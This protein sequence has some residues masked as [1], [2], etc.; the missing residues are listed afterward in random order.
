M[1]ATQ[2]RENP[3][4]ERDRRPAHERAAGDERRRCEECSEPGSPLEEVR[5]LVAE[6]AGTFALTLAAAGGEVIAQVSGGE[7]SHAARVVAPGLVVLALI[8]AIGNVSGA[9]FNPAVTF[10][11]ALRGVFRWRRVPAYWLAELCGALLAAVLLRWLFGTVAHL[12]ATMPHHGVR[13]AFVMEIALTWLLVMVILGTA[14]RHHLLGPNAAIAV[15]ATIALCGLFAGPVSGASMNPARSL[16]PA[17][18]AGETADVWI[19]LVAPFLGAALAVGLTWLL[20]GGP[21]DGEGEAAG[22]EHQH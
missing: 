14:T 5:C 11:F 22:G 2:E 16:G 12:G 1:V 9:H 15:G 18:V 6:M 20:R 19:Y 17:L 3:R 10:A 4:V 13:A 7:V 8:Y 21:G